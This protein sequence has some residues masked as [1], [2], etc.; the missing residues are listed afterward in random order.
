MTEKPDSKNPDA[1]PLLSTSII[2]KAWEWRWGVK[3]AYAIIFLD[4]ILL[5]NKKSGV[6]HFSLSM[7]EVWENFGLLP[8]AICA[9]CLTVSFIIPTL[10][11][12]LRHIVLF[13]PFD[14]FSSK[15]S[16]EQQPYGHVL[17]SDLREHALRNNND[18]LWKLY[19]QRIADFEQAQEHRE[20]FG[21]LIFGIT[22]LCLIDWW[23]SYKFG[24]DSL[25]SIILSYIGPQGGV[26]TL[27]I[28]ILFLQWAWFSEWKI[29]WIYYPPLY[30]AQFEKLQE[31]RKARDE[32]SRS[33]AHL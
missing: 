11:L 7:D 30:D 13:I 8:S 3:L 5:L 28:A 1:K 14:F 2:E 18:F 16:S 21:G 24:A 12:T 4:I 33:R 32:I 17:I 20:Q 26:I 29:R 27:M 19:E 23:A 25:T 9:F 31:Q 10:A 6:L 22:I 15:N